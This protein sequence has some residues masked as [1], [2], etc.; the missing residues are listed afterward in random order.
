MLAPAPLDLT[1][2]RTASAR[3]S[4]VLPMR[5][6]KKDMLPTSTVDQRER[7]GPND[8]NDR[9]DERAAAAQYAATQRA[10]LRLLA[11]LQQHHRVEDLA[12]VHLKQRGRGL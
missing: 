3:A 9:A 7:R 10:S 6:E 11:A 2:R 8:G 4:S 5:R 1:K 12:I